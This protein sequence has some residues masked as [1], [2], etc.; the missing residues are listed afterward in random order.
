MTYVTTKQFGGFGQAQWAQQL[1]SGQLQPAATSFAPGCSNPPS[2]GNAAICA[3]DPANPGTVYLTQLIPNWQA[4]PNYQVGPAPSSWSYTG[5][6]TPPWPGNGPDPRIAA[7]MIPAPMPVNPSTGL[8]I[9]TT[10]YSPAPLMPTTPYSTT[11][12]A[13][14]S[15][16]GLVLIAGGLMALVMV[17]LLIIKRKKHKT[18]T[19]ATSEIKPSQRKSKRRKK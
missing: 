12:A 16:S 13:T 10:S 5:S 8:P 6:G 17:A 11:P 14:S 7:P 2:Q 4:P 9:S 18:A 19:V 3:F 15:S 1:Q